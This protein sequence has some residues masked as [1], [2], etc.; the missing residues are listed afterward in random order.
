ML[1]IT[2]NKDKKD[3]EFRLKSKKCI[4]CYKEYQFNYRK[5][6]KN[7]S[8]EYSQ[9]YY[10]ENKKFILNKSKEYYIKNKQAVSDYKSQY[11][12]NN[13]E[14]LSNKNKIYYQN[15]K[16]ILDIKSKEYKINN[17]KSINKRRCERLCERREEINKKH[18]ERRKNDPVYRL[19]QN[20]RAYIRNSF[21]FKGLKKSTRTEIIL[22]CTFTDFKNHIETQFEPWMNWQN[23][24]LYNGELNYGWDIDHIIPISSAI[25]EN[26]VLKLNHF[27]NL[28][29]LCSLTNRHIKSGG[30]L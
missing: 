5:K 10:I 4:E 7:K 28:R 13:K 24:G 19:S 22:G 14:Y 16:E 25:N 1:C 17:R 6:H 3:F 20:I 9:N 23:Y 15:N 26:D 2:C 8:K 29:P 18:K 21:K 11:W 30:V 12:E 27:S